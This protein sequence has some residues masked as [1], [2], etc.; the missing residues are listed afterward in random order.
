M[1]KQMYPS[2]D[3]V[4]CDN[5]HCVSAFSCTHNIFAHIGF[6]KPFIFVFV[7]AT[8][9]DIHVLTTMSV[10]L[11]TCNLLSSQYLKP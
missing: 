4:K 1:E 9:T 8:V 11:G 2:D 10:H 6:Y 7:E 5:A 3:K